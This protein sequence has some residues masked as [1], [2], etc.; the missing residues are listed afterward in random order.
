MKRLFASAAAVCILLCGCTVTLMGNERN[1]IPY[2][3]FGT[4]PQKED[5]S[6]E[7]MY[8]TAMEALRKSNYTKAQELFTQLGDYKDAKDYLSR[9][10]YIPD[11][12]LRTDVY[13]NGVL[14]QSTPAVHNTT[15]SG[16]IFSS[17]GG[18]LMSTEESQDHGQVENWY[19]SGGYMLIKTYRKD[20]TLFSEKKTPTGGGNTADYIGG[21]YISYYYHP[22]GTLDK[23]QGEEY[24]H[25]MKQ[26]AKV[27]DQLNFNG[28][29][30]YNEAG[31][32]VMYKRNYSWGGQGHYTETYTYDEAGR[33]IKLETVKEG[34]VFLSPTAALSGQQRTE[35][36]LKEF[37]YD[38]DGNVTY[39]L[40]HTVSYAPGAEPTVV[41]AETEYTY[42]NGRLIG[43]T[44]TF[45]ENSDTVFETCYIYGDYL[46]Y[47]TGEEV[48]I[49]GG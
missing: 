30:T 2:E 3:T 20:G 32:L 49:S 12:L 8:K 6:K 15:G 47:I 9:F 34:D 43:E 28:T 11:T 44:S 4:M 39:T 19:Y 10:V 17:D 46:G 33:L 42:E 40:Q 48:A 41:H 29:Y 24:L 5:P 35:T 36:S 22:D 18:L 27:I 23:D 14:T 37:R 21:Y 13:T 1:E 7:I 45:G 31:L 38:E 16:Q 26:T 25:A